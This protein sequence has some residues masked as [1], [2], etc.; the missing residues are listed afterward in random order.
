[1]LALL[2]GW[3][4]RVI[5][6]WSL[7]SGLTHATW[8]LGW[9]FAAPYL[10]SPAARA[11]WARL[12]A[13]YGRADARYLHGDPF[14][15]AL[16]LCTGLVASSLN[17]WVSWHV[18][19][20]RRVAGALVALLVV[21]VMEAYGTVLYFGSE[22]F[23]HFANVDTTSAVHTWLMFVGLNALWLTFPG[24]CIYELCAALARAAAEKVNARDRTSAIPG[25]PL[26]V[27]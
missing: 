18:W 25:T 16:E 8:E 15:L 17:L 11:G 12:W 14:V 9:C 10:A 7:A 2:T 5:I 21:S 24:W 3:R 20:R 23:N 19:R 26:R 6:V 22:L 27:P 1:M 4:R 13:I